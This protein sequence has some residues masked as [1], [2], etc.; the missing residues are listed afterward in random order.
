M[1]VLSG[2]SGYRVQVASDDKFEKIVRDLKVTTA[3]ADLATLANGN[4]FARV[5]GIDAQGLE[6]FDSLKTLTV[7]DIQWRV[8]YSALSLEN[9]QSV[10]NWTGL[11]DARPMTGSTGIA[12]YSA[13][14]ARD[15]ALTQ[16][17]ATAEAG[18]ERV[19]LGDLKPGA[20]FIQL[21]SKMAAGGTL[22]SELYRFDIPA[23]WGDSVFRLNGVLE[24]VR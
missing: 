11:L 17:V 2:S 16:V 7:K 14:V 12:G 15:R 6:G 18:G 20:Y 9:G 19:A 22:D 5:R 24:P 23:G 3:S 4:W 10:L 8:S 1:P 13:L 21:R